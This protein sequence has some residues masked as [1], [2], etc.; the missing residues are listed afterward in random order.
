M[1][2]T[3]PIL[4]VKDV[5]KSSSWYQK[6]L[7]CKG[8]HGGT[9]FE[10]LTDMDGNQILSLHK[11]DEHGH[12]TLTNPKVKAGHGLILYFRVDNLDRLWQNAKDLKAFIEEEPH[13]NKNSGRMEF[14]LRDLDDYYISICAE[15]TD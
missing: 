4:A 13:L 2:K 1:I 8:I 9:S 15:V 12:P 11:W 5:N 7:N 3:E 6:L 10:I 14:S